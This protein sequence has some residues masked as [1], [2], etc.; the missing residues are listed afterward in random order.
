MRDLWDSV[1]RNLEGKL[2]AKELKTWFAPTRQLGFDEVSG[3]LRVE[4][5]SR[6]FVEWIEARHGASL[7]QA[8][9]DAG[10]PALSIRFD[11]GVR[12]PPRA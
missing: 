3:D 11:P 9:R 1:L 2:D 10:Y 8:A 5:P 7:S 12:G 6:V 4:V